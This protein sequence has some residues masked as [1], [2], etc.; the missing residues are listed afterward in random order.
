MEVE[1]DTSSTRSIATLGTTRSVMDANSIRVG[2]PVGAT[3]KEA[4]HGDQGSCFSLVA[5]ETRD[6]DRDYSNRGDGR[7]TRTT[8]RASAPTLETA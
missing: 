8:G 6:A 5:N 4:G 1:D 7:M 3:F 2:M